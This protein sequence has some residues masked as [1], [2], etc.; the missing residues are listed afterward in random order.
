VHGRL[1]RRPDWLLANDAALAAARRLEERLRT[2]DLVVDAE[3][4]VAF[5][6]RGLPRQ[7]SS[8]ASLEH[9]TRRMTRAEQGA[10]RLDAAVLYARAPDAAALMQFPEQ[11]THGA[12]H[13]PITYRFTPG[14]PQ[15]GATLALPLLALPGLTRESIDAAVPG[16]VRPR[17]EALLRTL[18]KEARR[19]LIPIAETAAQFVAA[20]GSRGPELGRLS[21]W[22]TQSRGIPDSLLRFAPHAIERHLTPQIAVTDAGRELARGADL[23]ALRRATAARAQAALEQRAAEVYPDA[24]HCFALDRLPEVETLTLAEG[25]LDVHPALTA[26]DERITVSFHWTAAEAQRQLLEG[27]TALAAM[28]LE[29]PVR[30]LAKRVRE[31]APLLLAAS[32]FVRGESLVDLLVRLTLRRACF[33]DHASLARD[34]AGFEAAVARGRERLQEELSD[35][36]ARALVWFTEAREL[37]RLL[38]DPRLRGQR[39]ATMAAQR[40]LKRLLDADALG[41]QPDAYLAELPRYLR[42]AERRWRRVLT[43][44]GEPPEIEL[45]LCEWDARLASLQ[46]QV[47]AE[48]RWLPALADLAWW[49]EEYRVS[50]YA[51]ELKTAR[52]VSAPRLARLAAEIE[53]WLRR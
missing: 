21:A 6:D 5:Y 41:M 19:S 40:H 3:T 37:R 38:D 39:E 18:P 34:R 46:Q 1:E 23:G 10:L 48:R 15:D 17:I 4:L 13:V 26:H 30:E 22:L 49:L 47:A 52:P 33:A 9:F 7:V 43:R 45:T 32:P 36:R 35:L 53:D 8:A 31:D 14:D 51:Q 24:W 29:R 2:R 50:L 12:V 42:A 27:A 28:L 25:R 11:F 16:F 44:G 20:A